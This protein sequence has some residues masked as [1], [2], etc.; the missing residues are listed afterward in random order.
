MNMQ[1]QPI[2]G[3]ANPCLFEVG[4]FVCIKGTK[5]VGRIA[6]NSGDKSLPYVVTILDGVIR[7]ESF[8]SGH[9]EMWTPRLAPAALPLD[10]DRL[11]TRMLKI[12]GAFELIED[13]AKQAGD[14]LMNHIELIAATF[15]DTAS[16]I[17]DELAK[18]EAKIGRPG[19]PLDERIGMSS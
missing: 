13:I 9:L 19:A 16:E 8:S 2:S 6:G 11:Q 15:A 4:H 5:D 12:L 17:L 10:I 1:V 7:D 3:L 18:R 14:G